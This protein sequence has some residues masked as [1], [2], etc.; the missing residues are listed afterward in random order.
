MKLNFVLMICR[1][2]LFFVAACSPKNKTSI[3]SIKE[4]VSTDDVSIKTVSQDRDLLDAK[5]LIKER[6]EV[7]K[8]IFKPEVD[9]YVGK[10]LLPPK[11]RPENLPALIEIKNEK[12]TMMVLSLYSS[13]GRVFGNCIEPNELLKTQYVLV[14]CNKSRELLSATYYYSDSLPWLEQPVISC[15]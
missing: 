7:V 6:L 5:V 4:G 8:G 12:Q 10:V 15:L 14:Y 3:F 11:C 13:K 1:V 9:A 2:L